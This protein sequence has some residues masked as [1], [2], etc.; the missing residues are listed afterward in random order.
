MENEIIGQIVREEGKFY[1]VKFPDSFEKKEVRIH[2]EVSFFIKP[3]V[4]PLGSIGSI[5]Y[6]IV[7]SVDGKFIKLQ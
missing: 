6:D 1:F 2:K 7:K 3:Y 5:R 4:T